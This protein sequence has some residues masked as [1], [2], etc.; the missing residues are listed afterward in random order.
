[1]CKAEYRK[2]SLNIAELCFFNMEIPHIIPSTMDIEDPMVHISY[3]FRVGH[4]FIYS[5]YIR[6]NYIP[7]RLI[8]A[9]L[10]TYT[11]HLPFLINF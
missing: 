10:L 11:T 8:V 9:S 2:F 5:F 1:M 6:T 7:T 3:I 4:K